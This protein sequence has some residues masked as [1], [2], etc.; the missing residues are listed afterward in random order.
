MIWL[1]HIILSGFNL[2]NVFIDAYKI[3]KLNK[4]IRHGINFG[5]YFLIWL[6]LVFIFK[7]N[8]I[9][10]AVFAF[11]AFNNRQITFDI[12]LNLRRGLPWDYMSTA[13]PPKAKWDQFERRLVGTNGKAITLIYAG[14]WLAS[15]VTWYFL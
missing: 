10:I 11:S 9:Q 2:V 13:N 4:E 1:P 3:K 15:L 12:L 7:M 14:L 6:A 5:A 8:W